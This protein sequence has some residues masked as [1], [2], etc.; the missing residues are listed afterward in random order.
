VTDRATRAQAEALYE[1]HME[2]LQKQAEQEKQA[3]RERGIRGYIH[4][5]Q[6]QRGEER[7]EQA[8]REAPPT[9]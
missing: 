2:E 1:Q 9:A 3:N 6:T 5:I 4:H 8:R 7:R